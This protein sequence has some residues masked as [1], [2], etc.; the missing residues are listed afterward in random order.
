MLMILHLWRNRSRDR[1]FGRAWAKAWAKRAYHIPELLGLCWRRYRLIRAGASVGNLTAIDR[2]AH[3][4]GS[5]KKR[6][7]IGER[8][9]I[10]R[11]TIPLH[12]AV[13]IGDRVSI[14]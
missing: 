11:V 10:G 7:H 14:N 3:F 9:A 8:C 4:T 13:W 12:T 5:H 2:G 1:I 6:L